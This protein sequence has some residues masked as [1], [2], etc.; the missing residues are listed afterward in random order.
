MSPY[1]AQAETGAYH[2][3]AFTSVPQV[4]RGSTLEPWHQAYMGHMRRGKE[5]G[6]SIIPAYYLSSGFGIL[7]KGILSRADHSETLVDIKAAVRTIWLNY[8]NHAL[9]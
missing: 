1:T 6:G 5:R 4:Y 8:Y 3:R 2:E 9:N 7:R